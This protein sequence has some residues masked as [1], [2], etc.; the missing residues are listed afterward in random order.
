MGGRERGIPPDR[1]LERTSRVVP[2]TAADESNALTEGGVGGKSSGVLQCALGAF[3]RAFRRCAGQGK[4]TRKEESH[5][6]ANN[7]SNV[8]AF[9]GMNSRENHGN[10]QLFASGRASGAK[11]RFE[12]G[13][14]ACFGGGVPKQARRVVVGEDDAVQVVGQLDGVDV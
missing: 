4:F 14:R 10:L 7:K 2:L 6:H 9:F 3:L 5:E 12:G 8:R 13:A 11:Q 1:A